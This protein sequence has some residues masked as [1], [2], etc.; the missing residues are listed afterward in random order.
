[1][2]TIK[3][4]AEKRMETGKNRA[5]TMREKHLI[6]GVI[7]SKGEE[8]QHIQVDHKEFQQVF[9][10][11]G[12]AS[13][14][15]ISLA[16]KSIPV[17]IREMQRHPVT[18]QILH[19]DFLMLHMNEKTRIQIPIILH[20][21]DN[22]KLKPSILSQLLDEIEIE[23]LPK[24]IPHA[25]EVDVA[26]IDFSTPIHV[27]DLDIAQNTKIT[28]HRELTDI[29]CTLTEPPRAEKEAAVEEVE[30]APAQ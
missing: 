1:M 13:V 9:R 4:K 6:P 19:L 30:A 8:T 10:E 12:V 27:K 21:K 18:N 29:V 23:C 20:N 25:A 16:G 15:H 17:I 22:V 7:Y 26:D 5:N 28:I 14:I 2:A 24:D 3:L 11:A